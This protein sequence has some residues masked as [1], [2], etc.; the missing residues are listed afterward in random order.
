MNRKPSRKL[1]VGVVAG[2]AVAGAGA[3]IGATQ[4][5]S[6]KEES[7]AIVNDAAKQLGIEPAKLS[8]A[9]K[10]ALQ[11]RVDAAVAAGRLTKEQGAELKSR[12]ESSDVPL[13]AGPGFRGG[14][15]GGHHGL[16]AD[17]GVAATYLGLTDA[18]LRTELEGG[19]SLADVAKAKGKSADGLVDALVTS[20]KTQLDEAVKNGRLTKEQETEM[21]N[22]LK[23][24]ITDLVNGRFPAPPHGD[25][26]FGDRFGGPGFDRARPFFGEGFG[27]NRPGAFRGGQPNPLPAA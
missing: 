6:P 25:R 10:K 24:R 26:F 16:I 4:L 12:I 3:A 20:A 15:H 8:A 23:A 27:G 5:G 7:Q 13:F 14:P 1:V 11:N 9:L 2:L 19:K 22:G 17:L 18:E 21:L